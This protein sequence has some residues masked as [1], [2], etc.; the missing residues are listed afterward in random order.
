MTGGYVVRDRALPLYGRYVYGDLCSGKL[1][2]ARLRG[3]RLVRPR[4][5]GLTLPYVVSFGEDAAGRLYGVSF[6]GDVYR[7]A[8]DPPSAAA[9]PVRAPGC[10]RS[11]RPG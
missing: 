9:R 4:P 8:R 6:V 10:R 5:L 1:F 3:T 7:F 11:C 2:S